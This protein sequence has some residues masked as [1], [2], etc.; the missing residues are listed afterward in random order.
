[1][2][3][4]GAV[5]VALAQPL[6]RLQSPEVWL[7]L[8][9][10]SPRWFNSQGCHWREA[11]FPLHWGLPTGLLK[12]PHSKVLGFPLSKGFKGKVKAKMLPPSLR[13][14]AP[15]PPTILYHLTAQLI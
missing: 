12:C 2:G 4:S 10:A 14:R 7:G 13:I 11:S 3:N 6:M 5:Q 15:S 8:E 1:M 9:N